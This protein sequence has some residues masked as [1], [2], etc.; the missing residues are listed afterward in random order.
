MT[1]NPNSIKIL[2]YGDSNTWGQNPK[3]KGARYPVNIRWTGLLQK[4]LGDEYEIVEE[5][6]SGRTTTLDG[7]PREGKNGNT[8]LKPCLETHNPIHI[9]V[10]MLGT[11][12]LKEQFHQSPQDIAQNVDLLVKRIK[13]FAWNKD[14]QTPQI[15]LLSPPLVDETVT[16]TQEKYKG[17]EEKSK[18]LGKY[19][20]EV[21]RRQN[22]AFIDI[23]QHIQ[24]SKYDG[25]HLDPEAQS[26]ISEVVERKIKEII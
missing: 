8:Y 12:D 19:Y 25:Y 20:Q 13:E 14:R 18:Q 9:V 6:L 1:I 10:L 4:K 11:N 26:I 15:I 24:P 16:G 5:G 22:C 21:A 3:E 23:A 17:A 2:C 7:D